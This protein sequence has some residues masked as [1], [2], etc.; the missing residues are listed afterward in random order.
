MIKFTTTQLDEYIILVSRNPEFVHLSPLEVIGVILQDFDIIEVEITPTQK[1]T[2]DDIW[3][4]NFINPKILREW[5]YFAY[6]SL[7]DFLA[8]ITILDDSSKH[9]IKLLYS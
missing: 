3:H 7:N 1:L 9:Q 2:L 8:D 5:K 4:N 6:A